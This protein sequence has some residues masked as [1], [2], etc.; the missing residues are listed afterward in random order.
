MRIAPLKYYNTSFLAKNPNT[1]TDNCNAAID[2]ENDTFEY[3]QDMNESVH[4]GVLQR[5]YS[6]VQDKFIPKTKAQIALEQYKN[7]KIFLNMKIASDEEQIE[8]VLL[9][10]AGKTKND[11]IMYVNPSRVENS[12]VFYKAD[13]IIVKDKISAHRDR[14]VEL[15]AQLLGAP[16]IIHG[17]KAYKDGFYGSNYI[18]GRK[19]ADNIT[20]LKHD[21]NGKITGAE[22]YHNVEFCDQC[23]SIDRSG[24][25]GL[26]FQLRSQRPDCKIEASEVYKTKDGKPYS[27]FINY[28]KLTD[29][30]MHPEFYNDYC[31]TTADAAIEFLSGGMA[32]VYT[33]FVQEKNSIPSGTHEELVDIK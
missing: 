28:T 8:D 18:L 27:Y 4:K 20:V 11:G 24:M 1:R 26:D 14:N 15:I 29:A 12:E 33:D 23:W 16:M 2:F 25:L 30:F 10:N 6:I 13:K 9:L 21:K 7:N 19:T 17:L 22:T 5:L 3:Q 31:E 32:D